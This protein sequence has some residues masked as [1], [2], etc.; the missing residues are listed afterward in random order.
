MD[1][2][3]ST[4]W[5]V[6]SRVCPLFPFTIKRRKRRPWSTS[7]VT[8]VDNIF[9]SHSPFFSI[10]T[11][12]FFHFLHLLSCPDALYLKPLAFLSRPDNLTQFSSREDH[13]SPPCSKGIAASELLATALSICLHSYLSC[14]L[15]TGPV[16]WGT[17]LSLH[18]ATHYNCNPTC[19]P[20]F[21]CYSKHVGFEFFIQSILAF[22]VCLGMWNFRSR[23]KH[24]R[25]NS[26]M[27]VLF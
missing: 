9:S 11:R 22:A 12:L 26:E 10:L 15:C 17:Y 1:Y 6:I 18:P 2:F 7:S 16:P 14:S 8:V 24:I 27:V 19:I 4:T 20:L 25:L 5:P 13:W 23:P 3:I 21:I